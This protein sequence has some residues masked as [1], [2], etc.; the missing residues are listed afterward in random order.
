MIRSVTVDRRAGI[1]R[2]D[3]P[4]GCDPTE[5]K[6]AEP[7]SQAP[8]SLTWARRSPVAFPAPHFASEVSF[9]GLLARARRRTAY[10]TATEVPISLD[11]YWPLWAPGDSP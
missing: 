7:S 9:A 10:C 1:G 4:K 5:A 2:D 3:A 6:A 11:Q 8:G